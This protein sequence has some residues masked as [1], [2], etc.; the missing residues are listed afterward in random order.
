MTMEEKKAFKGIEKP[1]PLSVRGAGPDL[2]VCTV[3]QSPPV[4]LKPPQ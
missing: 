4:Q 1:A 2:K 3:T